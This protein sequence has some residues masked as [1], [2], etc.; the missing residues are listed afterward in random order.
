MANTTPAKSIPI[1]TGLSNPV[2]STAPSSQADN[3]D[4]E[5]GRP[6]SVSSHGNHDVSHTDTTAKDANLVTWDGPDDPE[7]PKNWPDGLKWK[8]TWAVSMFVF[9]SPVSSAMIAPAMQSLAS[10]LGMHGQFETYMSLAIF[11]L[12]YTVGPILF[13]PASELYGRVR[14][15]QVSNL[16]Y[17]AWNLGC[18]FAQTKGQFFA[19]RFLAG[20]GGSAPLA[21]GGGAIRY[22]H[23]EYCN[24]VTKLD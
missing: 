21:L 7:F 19:F 3:L 18:G 12:A 20:M 24:L 23:I 14:L 2:T 5:K 11:I 13:G 1:H 9:I 15:L 17:L 22:V 8:V 10:S 4:L 6:G 16:W